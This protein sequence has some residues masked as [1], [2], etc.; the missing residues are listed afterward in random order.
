MIPK[1]SF[2]DGRVAADRTWLHISVK[3]AMHMGIW[4]A[5]HY[6]IAPI[7]DLALQEK[8]VPVPH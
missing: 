4:E 7:P 1:Y 2:D 5:L 3:K 6:L 8:M